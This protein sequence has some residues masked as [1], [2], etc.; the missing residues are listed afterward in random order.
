LVR[1]RGGGVSRG[2]NGLGHA[3]YGEGVQLMVELVLG[4]NLSNNPPSPG[5]TGMWND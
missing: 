1:A 4:A 2:F 5:V 3:C